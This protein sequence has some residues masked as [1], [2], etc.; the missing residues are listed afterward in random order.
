MNRPVVVINITG[1]VEQ[2]T[3]TAPGTGEPE[4]VILDFDDEADLEWREHNLDNYERALALLT[5][6]GADLGD[7]KAGVID[8]RRRLDALRHW[9]NS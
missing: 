3:M 2:W 9:Y 8:E 1:G 6:A 4:V 7:M 5:E